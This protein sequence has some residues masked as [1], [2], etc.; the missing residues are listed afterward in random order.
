MLCVVEVDMPKACL[1]LDSGDACKHKD[2]CPAYQKSFKDI[3]IKFEDWILLVDG[4]RHPD[5]P[6]KG[7]Y[8][9]KD[10]VQ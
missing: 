3:S 9:P 4:K 10:T 5:C 8:E 7:E 1:E 6:F 2:Y